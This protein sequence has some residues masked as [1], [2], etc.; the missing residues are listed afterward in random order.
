MN[1]V[2]AAQLAIDP[3]GLGEV[4]RLAGRDDAEA[5][6]KA[7]QS[8]EALLVNQLMKSMREANFGDDLFESEA[9]KTFTGMLD[10]Q[11]ADTL[12]RG[13]GL[14]LA[15]MIVRQV[16]MARESGL[17]KTPSPSVNPR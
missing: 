4:R 6:R 9:T 16:E 3:Q 11:Y 17:Q 12:S 15:D 2:E 1:R 10:Q 7:A 13:R 5:L 14:G 8:F